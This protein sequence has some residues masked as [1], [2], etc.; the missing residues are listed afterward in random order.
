LDA[1]VRELDYNALKA[2]YEGAAEAEDAED[3]GGGGGSAP[4]PRDESGNAKPARGG[5]SANGSAH[6]EKPEEYPLDDGETEFA[7]RDR[8]SFVDDG[9]TLEG[10]VETVDRA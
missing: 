5:S 3:A 2:I 7:S 10:V 6:R 4:P 9:D 1:L 8:V